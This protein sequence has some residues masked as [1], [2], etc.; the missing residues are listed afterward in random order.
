M[1]KRSQEPK[2]TG[3]G[4][5]IIGLQTEDVASAVISILAT[6][7]NVIVSN[8]ITEIIIELFKHFN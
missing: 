1:I 5:K 8:L 6:P 7:A 3:Q 4:T 2:P